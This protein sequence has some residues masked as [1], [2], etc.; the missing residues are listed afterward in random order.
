MAL[1]VGDIVEVIDNKNIEDE[2]K[3]G[4][5]YKITVDCNSYS[6]EQ[7]VQIGSGIWY[8]A[9]RFRKLPE[10]TVHCGG[11][12]VARSEYDRVCAELESL[13]RQSEDGPPLHLLPENIRAKG[14]LTIDYHNSVS[15]HLT[16]P[17]KKNTY[18]DSDFQL[19]LGASPTKNWETAIWEVDT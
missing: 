18:W 17:E 4:F 15:L 16:K 5:R 19:Y 7:F 2:I 9:K 10:T 14:W 8:S 11:P 13:K 3:L 6:D 12:Y 1:N